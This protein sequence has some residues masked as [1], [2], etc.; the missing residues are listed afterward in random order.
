MENNNN[1]NRYDLFNEGDTRTFKDYLNLIRQNLAPVLIISLAGLIVAVL[2][3]VTATDIYRSTT[4]LKLSKPQGNILESPLMPEFQDFGSDRFVA[5]EIELLKSFRVRE[6]VANDLVSKYIKADDKD[7]F[8]LIVEDNNDKT[9]TK[10]DV[11]PKMEIVDML[12]STVEIEQ[13]RGLDF[14]EISV[15]SP[16]PVEAAMIANDY[17]DAYRELNLLINRQQLIS[18]REFLSDQRKSKLEELRSSENALQLFQEEG[19][20]VELRRA[21]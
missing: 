6:R 21:G 12:S 11:K 13:K 17:A 3:A 16:S 1:N 9:L 7:K 4:T 10:E 20:I 18:V 15:E 14:V 5:N 19:G 8:S 2:Y